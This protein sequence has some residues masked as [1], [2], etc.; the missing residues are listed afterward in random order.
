MN[1][2]PP[3]LRIWWPPIADC[4]DEPGTSEGARNRCDW[5]ARLILQSQPAGT[6]TFLG[7]CLTG[8]WTKGI[9]ENTS[10]TAKEQ[11]IAFLKTL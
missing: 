5:E 1:Q 2:E 7:L 4:S 9:T 6:L 3:T 11:L 10:A 8:S